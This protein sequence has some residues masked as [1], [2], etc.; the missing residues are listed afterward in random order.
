MSGLTGHIG[1]LMKTAP[2]PPLQAFRYPMPVSYQGGPSDLILSNLD[3]KGTLVYSAA[4]WTGS[5]FPADWNWG[6]Q[7]SFPIMSGKRA[8][9]YILTMPGN[10]EYPTANI[11]I[12]DKITN[13]TIIDFSCGKDSPGYGW[14]DFNTYD[15]PSSNFY[16][17]Q[18]IVD[19]LGDVFRVGIHFDC[20]TKDV[21]FYLD[22]SFVGSILNGFYTYPEAYIGA[23]LSIGGSTN[24][25][26]ISAEIVTNADDMTGTYPAGT[27]D[28][29]G[30]LI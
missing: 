19:G 25:Y 15:H 24:G 27:M 14:L 8:I 10:T 28:F 1:I 3:Q 4:K 17:A 13:D 30:N 9:E 2:P 21:S 26:T 16:V 5:M 18:N 11:Y 20:D 22:G 29:G 23:I 12:K 7:A 6:T